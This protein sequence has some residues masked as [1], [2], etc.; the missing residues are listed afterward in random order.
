MDVA[1]IVKAWLIKNSII[2]DSVHLVSTNLIGMVKVVKSSQSWYIVLVNTIVSRCSQLI[3][4]WI[5]NPNMVW[6]PFEIKLIVHVIQGG[7]N[8]LNYVQI[9]VR[10]SLINL[11]FY[12][13]WIVIL[14]ESAVWLSLIEKFV[15]GSK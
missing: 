11:F 14:S 12:G 7:I 10:V 2:S 4:G 8:F 13:V 6:R 3:D 15:T 5:T 9:Y 1:Y